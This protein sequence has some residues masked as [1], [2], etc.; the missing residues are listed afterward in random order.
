MAGYGL[1]VRRSYRICV[2]AEST[3]GYG[4]MGLS[5]RIFLVG[6]DDSVRR[7]SVSFGIMRKD[8]RSP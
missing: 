6:D 3:G 1:K 4:L 7:F 2:Q 8:G 5:L